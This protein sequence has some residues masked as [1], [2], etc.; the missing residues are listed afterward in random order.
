MEVAWQAGSTRMLG[1]QG[2]IWVITSLIHDTT[3]STMVV[4]GVRG[5]LGP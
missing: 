3:L 1:L 4:D 5:R 2:E